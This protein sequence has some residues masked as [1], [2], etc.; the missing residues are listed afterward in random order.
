VVQVGT[1]A[2][3][4]RMAKPAMWVR[5]VAKEEGEEVYAMLPPVLAVA[6]RTAC[7]SRHC[8]MV[9]VGQVGMP[10]TTAQ[11]TTRYV[12]QALALVR[13]KRLLVVPILVQVVVAKMANAS[14][15]CRKAPVGKAALRVV[16]VARRKCVTQT[17]DNVSRNRSIILRGLMVRHCSRRSLS[18][19]SPIVTATV[20][21]RKMIYLTR[22]KFTCLWLAL[23]LVALLA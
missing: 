16:C 18:M 12:T 1:L 20:S 2:L 22:R 4:A 10:V 14:R 19:R 13:T 6:V 21:H 7:V 17:L 15:R 5:V 8:R 3:L 11:Q 9:L 23:V